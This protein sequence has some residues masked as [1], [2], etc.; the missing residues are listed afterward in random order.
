MGL[1][2]GAT[3]ACLLPTLRVELGMHPVFEP[4]FEGVCLMGD[5]I[6]IT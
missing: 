1:T 2:N 6:A 4:L 3:M 5:V